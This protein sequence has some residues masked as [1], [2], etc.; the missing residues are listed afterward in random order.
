MSKARFK[1]DRK[2]VGELLKSTEMQKVLQEYAGRVQGQMGAEFE[3]YIAG[4][5]AVVGS[6]SKKGDKQAMKD[7]KLLKALGGSRRK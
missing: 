6:K 3:T 7:N 1:L 5:R 4:T 2:G